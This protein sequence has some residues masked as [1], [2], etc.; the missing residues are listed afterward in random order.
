MGGKG[1][2]KTTVGYKYYWDVQAGLGRGPADE[3]VS[4][5]ADDKIVFAGTAGEV[6]KSTS[7]YIDKPK[8]FGG[9]DVGG[10]GGI[11]GTLEVAMGEP[12]QVPSAALLKLLT[13][14]VPAFRGVVTTF[15]SGLIS[16]F[17]ANPKPWKYRLRR[18]LKGW[19]GSVWYPEKAIIWLE[20][21]NASLDTELTAGQVANMQKIQAMNPAHILLEA[22]TNRDWGR[23]LDRNSELNLD[24]YKAAADALF[25]EQFGLCFRYN[26]QD[27]LDTFI[28]QILDHICAAQYCD[29][30]TGRLTLKLIR[31]DYEPDTLP[32]F[33]YD[34]GIV[35]IQDDDSTSQDSSPNEITVTYRDPVTNTDGY[36]RA[37][38][39]GAI[40][41]VGLIS[42]SVEYPAIPTH[43]LASLLAQR[44]LEM[45]T[46]GL[47][48]LV[49]FF[50]RRAHA[51]APAS[52][53]RITAKDRGIENMVLRVGKIQE[54]DDG[55]LKL[56][57]VQDVFS[58]SSTVYSGSESPNLWV[59]PDTHARPVT[60]WAL[61][62]LPYIVLANSLPTA[63]LN[64][65]D[66]SSCFIGV[67][68][69]PPNFTQI[70]YKLLT[71]AGSGW[72]EGGTGDWTPF[73]KLTKDAGLLD[74]VLHVQFSFIPAV[75]AGMLLGN[76]L[77][78]VDA[79]NY[80]T[81][82]I[83]VGRGCADTLP[84]KHY[85]DDICW[86][87]HNAIESDDIEYLP[88][89]TVQS[90]L[91][92]STNQEYLS[93]DDAVAKSVTLA[94][95]QDRPYLPGN[96]R[97]NDEPY[98]V[99]ASPA[100]EYI[101]S[102]SHR[103]RVLQADRLIDCMQSGIGPEQNVIYKVTLQSKK[104]GKAIWSVDLSDN[105]VNVPYTSGSGGSEHILTLRAMRDN[106]SSA[107]S[108]S[109]SLPDGDYT[110]DEGK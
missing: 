47:K 76:E 66:A 72:A 97:L 16:S 73:L 54:Q 14:L 5:T 95:R 1:K 34:N 109:I 18:C 45:V 103:D 60:D 102:W 13:G 93:P 4:I 64:A 12:E 108:W 99:V 105:R 35:E 81:G 37:Q 92:T 71:N 59:P 89:E 65:L 49:I 42:N 77:V 52:V 87:Y 28:Q 3:L 104:T 51:L 33:T 11:Q 63:E 21:T 91:I 20:N 57:V 15:Y 38:N 48:R 8:L 19:D 98:P 25:N 39:L 85:V 24:S 7:I 79:I 56:T 17:S 46:T 84:E 74:T 50:D 9:D 2:K 90:K 80:L 62:E 58:L 41:A 53:F 101:L 32:L 29:A 110:P 83:V 55:R 43:S 61:F 94:G 6:T 107:M 30:E 36:V 10:E 70:N 23:G 96:I 40:T 69:T 22:A 100:T 106:V 27:S 44:D 68:A 78:R 67:V 86:V 82:E 26:R 88:G 75:G 31:D